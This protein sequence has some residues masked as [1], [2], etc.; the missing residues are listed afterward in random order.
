MSE[1]NTPKGAE[2]PKDQKKEEEKQAPSE[3]KSES[4]GSG[5][6]AVDDPAAFEK[7]FFRDLHSQFVVNLDKVPTEAFERAQ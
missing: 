6:V 3:E 1:A 2:A 7:C 4:S 5:S